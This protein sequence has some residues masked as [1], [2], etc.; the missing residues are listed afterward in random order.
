MKWTRALLG[1]A[2]PLLLVFAPEPAAASFGAVAAAT[3]ARGA[4]AL[5]APVSDVELADQRGGFAFRGMEV[6]FGANLRTYVD[7]A[8]VLESVFTLTNAGLVQNVLQ[9]AGLAGLE[10]SAEALAAAGLRVDSLAGAV[11]GVAVFGQNG[12]TAALHRLS[13]SGFQNIVLNTADFRNITQTLDLMI[14]LNGY[15]A[16]RPVLMAERFGFRA[17]QDFAHVA[18][19]AAAPP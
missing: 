8:L 17:A 1:L 7:G 13:A 5:P 9:S 19:L 10:T 6:T 3:R 11:G 2:L 18:A 16:L 12:A 14:K 15:E 4:P